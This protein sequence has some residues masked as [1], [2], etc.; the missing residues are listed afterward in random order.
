[1][2]LLAKKVSE[3][4]SP[5]R[6]AAYAFIWIRFYYRVS[7]DE[8]RE[9]LSKKEAISAALGYLLRGKNPERTWCGT[10]TGCSRT[11]KKASIVS[12]SGGHWR[13]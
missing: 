9:V 7:R 5:W 13:S 1:M 10:Y 11:W 4:P 2:D 8:A 3:E 6:A 12:G